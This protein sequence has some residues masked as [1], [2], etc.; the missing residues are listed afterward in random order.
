MVFWDIAP[1][2]LMKMGW[3]ILIKYWYPSSVLIG[4]TSETTKLC[5]ILY[6]L[7]SVFTHI[8]VSIFLMYQF[9]SFIAKFICKTAE[10]IFPPPGMDWLMETSDNYESICMK[11]TASLRSDNWQ[12]LYVAFTEDCS[13][14]FIFL[15][16]KY[17]KFWNGFHLIRLAYIIFLLYNIFWFCGMFVCSVVLC[18]IWDQF[19]CFCIFF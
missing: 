1:H 13:F 19:I 11:H 6:R 15:D 18:W 14:V 7:V 9:L 12:V 10:I 8:L 5:E 16:P 17:L 4:I 2:S 3:Q